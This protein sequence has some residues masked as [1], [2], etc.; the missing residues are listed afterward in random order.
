MASNNQIFDAIN[1]VDPEIDYTGAN[2]DYYLNKYVNR[3]EDAGTLE[4]IHKVFSDMGLVFPG[5][6]ALNAALYTVEGNYGKAAISFA[7]ILPAINEIR[8]TQQVLKKSGEPLVKIYRGYRDWYPGSMI[9]NDHFVSSGERSM[10]MVKG[11]RK[12]ILY[13]TTDKDQAMHYAQGH[14]EGIILE[15]E[16]PQSY[17]LKNALNAWGKQALKTIDDLYDEAGTYL[18]MPIWE[19]GLPKQFLKKVHKVYDESKSID[20]Y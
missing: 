12:K 17:V 19:K 10:R 7:S 2:A 8:K 13:T 6:D 16:V 15:F 1:N 11:E 20:V 5:A 4:G 3:P 14:K 18:G 9:K